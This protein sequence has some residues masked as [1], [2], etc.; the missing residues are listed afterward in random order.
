MKKYFITGVS[1]GLGLELM[2]QLV[3]RGDF[4]YGVSRKKV[5][6]D[7]V[8]RA[9][10]DK[11]VWRHCDVTQ[12]NEILHTIEHQQSINFFP[13]VVILNAG[14]SS[15]D[16][17]EFL[18]NKYQELFQVNCFGAL[19]WVEEYLKEFKKVNSGHFVYISSLANFYPF[20]I[21]ANY[22]ATKAYT[23]MVFECLKKKYIL[24]GIKFSVFYPGLIETEMSSTAPVP[25]FFKFPVEKAARKI[26][27]TLPKGSQSVR[28]PLRSIFL[29][30]MLAIIPDRFL[31]S[32]L[33]KKYP[34][35]SG[36]NRPVQ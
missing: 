12:N 13:D 32:L 19:K 23:S 18:L 35:H 36:N 25:G 5:L 7:P 22:S 14:A 15:R 34:Q 21:R 17:E 4:V 3:S 10:K 33:D 2:K 29:E 8:L 11:W 9:S 31:L 27:D 6:D 1:G 30:W 16:D 20:P 28:F 24:T 26:L